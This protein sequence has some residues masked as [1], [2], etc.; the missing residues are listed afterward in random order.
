[1]ASVSE[2]V[3]NLV[4][5]CAEIQRGEKVLIVNEQGAM[6]PDVVSLIAEDVRGAGASPQVIW[7]EPPGRGNPVPDELLQAIASSDKVIDSLGIGDKA[8]EAHL[9]PNPHVVV[10]HSMFRTKDHFA[11]E[12]ARY[13]WGMANAIYHRFEKELFAAGRRWQF[14]ARAGTDISGVIG[15]VSERARQL[16]DDRSPFSRSFNSPAYIPVASNSCEGR[17]VIEYTGGFRRI[18][19][20]HPPTLVIE[21]N[22]IRRV[23]GPPEGKRWVDEYA[24]IL[25]ERQER[26][27]IPDANRVDSWH[28][29]LHPIAELEGGDRGLIGNA[30]TS[31]AHFHVGPD[32]AHI[33]AQW[34]NLTMELDGETVIEGGKYHPGFDDPKLREAAQRFG[35]AYWR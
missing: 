12:H 26:M 30:S 11:S 34:G 9:G 31:M 5:N 6:D 21:G 16:E 7:A 3:R 15:A 27:A 32:G 22:V 8:L 13:H 2:G 24:K 18:P 33:Q 35:L 4:A 14:T 23:E 1:M 10:I 17:A 29:G 19:I 20:D 25:D 28:G